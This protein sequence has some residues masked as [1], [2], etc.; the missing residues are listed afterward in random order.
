[1]RWTSGRHCSTAGLRKRQPGRNVR[2]SCRRVYFLVWIGT[3][4]P[5]FVRKTISCPQCQ[6]IAMGASGIH[7]AVNPPLWEALDCWALTDKD[8][9][10]VA[11]FPQRRRQPVSA[12]AGRARTSGKRPVASGRSP[13]SPS[14]GPL[15]WTVT[16]CQNHSAQ[17][18]VLLNC[19]PARRL[20]EL[21]DRISPHELPGFG[22]R[23]PAARDL[24]M[25]LIPDELEPL[26][27]S[28]RQ[29]ST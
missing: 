1:M 16:S 17:N 13:R 21:L 12:L 28:C 18:G 23:R 29:S 19:P 15:S 7:G 10:Y 25:A 11:L 14:R 2:P 26:R 6:Q 8:E 4:L 22:F 27:R 9:A 3:T 5:S 20:G 24:R